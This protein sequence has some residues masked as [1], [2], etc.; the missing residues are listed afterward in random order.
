[1]D[2]DGD[3]FSEN[4]YGIVVDS[5]PDTQRLNE[6]LTQLAHAALQNQTLSFSTIMKIFTS[7]SLSEI[8][9]IIEKDERDIQERQAQQA[10]EQSKMQ[11]KQLDMQQA[12]QDKI[13]AA[14]D[15]INQRDNETK[16]LI[17]EMDLKLKEG[18]D[19]EPVEESS[20]DLMEKI[21]QFDKKMAL[22]REQFIHKKT[23]DEKTISL[24][25][26]DLQIKKNNKPNGSR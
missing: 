2:I 24:K 6:N 18:P 16:I 9:R 26:K 15:E 19:E 5:S 13:L 3:E 25:E 11:E 8:Q 20:V 10:Q 14:Q 1:M 12:Q 17:K 21:R 7:P 4:D 22:E 23:M